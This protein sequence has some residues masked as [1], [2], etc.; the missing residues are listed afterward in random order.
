MRVSP[1]QENNPLSS[2]FCVIC[3]ICVCS[4]IE[5]VHIQERLAKYIYNFLDVGKPPRPAD[6]IFVMAGKQERKVFGIKMWRIGYAPQL[7]LSVGRFEWR[8]FKALGL[9]SDGGLESLVAQIPPKERHFLVRLTRQETLCTPVKPGFL[10]TYS[11][12]RILSRYLQNLPIRSLLVV[13]SPI[14]L[15]RVA[16]VFRRAFRKSGT[17]L[18]FASVPENISFDTA[19]SRVQLWLELC[20]YVV[21]R[22]L[23]L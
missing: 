4:I 15:R 20:K 21:Y 1:N 9:E 12:A 16:L 2:S 10:G 17:S 13:S 6:C 18:T 22:L 7:I 5:Y 23:F 8:K 3:E 14:H 19:A 11:E